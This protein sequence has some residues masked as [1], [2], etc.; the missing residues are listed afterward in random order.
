[1]EN[2]LQMA[3]YF[4]T[5]F[6]ILLDDHRKQEVFRLTV[7]DVQNAKQMQNIVLDDEIEY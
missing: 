7:G 3:I 6:T 5:I 4:R 2:Y 1:M